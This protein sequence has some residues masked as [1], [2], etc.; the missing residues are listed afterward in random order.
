MENYLVDYWYIT[1]VTCVLLSFFFRKAIYHHNASMLQTHGAELASALEVKKFN[2]QMFSFPNLP[3][4]KIDKT[5]WNSWQAKIAEAMPVQNHKRIFFFDFIWAAFLLIT[6]YTL[7]L[8]YG[9]QCTIP[10]LFTAV[11]VLAYFFDMLENLCYLRML[12]MLYKWLPMI[13]FVKLLLY[14]A[15]LLWTILLLII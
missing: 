11:L 14:V 3:I 6:L 1:I 8:R 2:P 13:S 9:D 10:I 4:Q 12:E 15:G 7:A 5:R